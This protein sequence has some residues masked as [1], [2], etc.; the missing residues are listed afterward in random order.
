MSMFRRPARREFSGVTWDEHTGQPRV[1]RS[2]GSS[3]N[4]TLDKAM[5]Q[6]AFWAC[7]RLRADLLSTFPVDVFR[8]F[9]VGGQMVPLEMPKPP[10]LVDPGGREWDF[11]DWMWASQRDLDTAGNTIGKIV[12]RNGISTPYYPQGLPAVIE[13]A[14][15][16]ACSVIRHKGELLYR[17]DGKIY[18]PWEIFHERQY[19]ASGTP[20]GLSPLM[21]AAKTVG[22]LLEMQQYGLDWFSKGGIPKAWMK[23]T[24]KRLQDTE[25]DA[26]KQWY[27]DTVENGSLMVTGNDWEYNMIQAETAGME[28][29]NGRQFGLAEICRFLGVPAD[30]VDAA[31]TGQSITYANM[32]ERNLQFLIMNLGPAVKRRERTLTRLLPQPRYV[33]LNTEGLLRMTPA[34]RQTILRSQ[35][36]TWQITLDETR[37][38]D[39]RAP[40]TQGELDRMRDIYGAPKISGSS[41]APAAPDPAD[42]EDPDG[43]TAE[44]EQS[45]DQADRDSADATA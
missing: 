2:A 39:N 19:P 14:D 29:I 41:A 15:T 37:K 40:L 36:E 13:L 12:A 1:S 11:I 10:I 30:L 3:V 42:E 43:Q 23:N 9:Q 28:W 38:L 22:E 5:T 26:A 7:V 4:V 6:S 21:H 8:D 16:R 34:L 35:L 17:V 18:Q 25:R 33:K 24:V 44:G 45:G 32:T 20:V 27:T 31:I